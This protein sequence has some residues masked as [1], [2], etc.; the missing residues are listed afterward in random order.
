MFE[1]GFPLKARLLNLAY[2]VRDTITAGAS[3][4]DGMC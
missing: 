3:H 4:L 1:A 2:K